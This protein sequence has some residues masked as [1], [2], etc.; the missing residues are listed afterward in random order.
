MENYLISEIVGKFTI[1]SH[2]C[3][4]FAKELNYKVCIITKEPIEQKEIDGLGKELRLKFSM[5]VA[6]DPK[7]LLKKLM[8]LDNLPADLI[9]RIFI[10]ESLVRNAKFV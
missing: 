9:P 4:F 6:K 3:K 5:V 7:T 8:F 2:I 10:L 1:T